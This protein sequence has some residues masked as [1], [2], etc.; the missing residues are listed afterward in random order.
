MSGDESPAMLP[1]SITG[2]TDGTRSRIG[3]RPGDDP[4]I[5]K[6]VGGDGQAAAA[7]VEIMPSRAW[8]AEGGINNL[9][10]DREGDWLGCVS[11]SRLS[12][13]RV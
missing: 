5:G 9:A 2:G 6:D 12:V 7:A 13:L 8:S 11:G 1:A 4:N 3:G 10:F